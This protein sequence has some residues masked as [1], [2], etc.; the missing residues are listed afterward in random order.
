MYLI[1]KLETNTP[2]TP[3]AVTTLDANLVTINTDENMQEMLKVDAIVEIRTTGTSNAGT[4]DMPIRITIGGATMTYAFR[5]SAIAGRRR[6][7]ISFAS[8]SRTKDTIL[9]DMLAAAAA[10]PQTTVTVNS[11]YVWAINT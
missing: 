1:T 10:D 8:V 6:E 4:Q 5:A 11:V 7:P 9:I 3:T 2:V